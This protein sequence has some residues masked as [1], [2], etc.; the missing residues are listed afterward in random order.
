MTTRFFA[1]L[2]FLSLFLCLGPLAPAKEPAGNDQIAVAPSDWPW[3]RGPDRNGVARADQ[4]LPVKWGEKENVLWKTAVP[5]RGHASPTVVG[6]RV[7]LA[8]ADEEQEI[9]SV[10]CYDRKTGNQ[11]WNTAIHR[12]GFKS[13]GRQGNSKSSKASSTVACN[14]ERLFITFMNDNAAFITALDLDGNQLWQKKITDYVMHQGYGSSPAIYGPLVIVSADN[15]GGGAIAAYDR[16]SGELV[17]RHNRPE[18]PNYASP[19]ILQVDGRDQL[20]FTGCDLVSSYDPL[21]GTKNWEIPGAT[22]ECVTS[23]VTD[24]KH[25]VTSGGYPDNHISVVRGDGSG[26]VVWRNK[27][28]VYVPSMIVK[29]GYLYGV[30]DAGIAV[31]YELETGRRVWRHRLDAKFTASPILV[32]DNIYA[33]SEDG[34]TFIFKADPDGYEPLG[35]N[36]LGDEVYATPSICGGRIYMRVAEMKDGKRQEMLY[37]IGQKN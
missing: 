24:G 15:K 14:G 1:A 30:M 3:W 11:L 16:K 25:I 34:R 13:K 20:I 31:C 12:G 19:I 4:R 17:W 10:V 23:T 21:S 2:C 29:D 22:T 5:G 18:L 37:C 32:G 35:E 36:K 26:K 33:V 28:R 7:Y 27:S 6:D 8:T 9:Q